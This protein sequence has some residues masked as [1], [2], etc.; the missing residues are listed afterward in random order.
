MAV[1]GDWIRSAVAGPKLSVRLRG[2]NGDLNTRSDGKKQIYHHVV[3]ANQ[4]RWSPAEAVRVVVTALS[5]R[6]PD[7]SFFPEPLLLPLQLTWAFP[8]VHELLP[9][10]SESD[11]CDLGSIDEG[12][13]RFRLSTYITPN[14]FRGY[15]SGG[16]AMRVTVV[17]SV[18]NCT[19]P[20]LMIEISWD[21]QWST[22]LADMQ[23]HLVIKE[24][25][26]HLS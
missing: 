1:W 16:E 19:S 6:R 23:R 2:G 26:S 10:V 17:A 22:D 9:T 25:S 14:N 8:S 20:P 24:V 3:V 11:T 4:R 12:S 7:G 13:G 18:Y 21:G 15:L 5:R